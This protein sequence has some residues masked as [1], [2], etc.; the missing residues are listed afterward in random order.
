LHQFSAF[1]TNQNL[2][3]IQGAI[4]NAQTHRWLD[5]IGFPPDLHCD[6]PTLARIRPFI[7]K[8]KLQERQS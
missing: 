8:T 3:F 5:N 6:E 1:A 7:A 4:M 2:V